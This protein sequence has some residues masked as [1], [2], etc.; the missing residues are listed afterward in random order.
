MVEG[1]GG[2]ENNSLL[3]LAQIKDKYTKGIKLKILHTYDHL[4]F[5]KTAEN[6]QWKKQ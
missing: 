2:R 4:I 1:P 5:D 3:V 6:I